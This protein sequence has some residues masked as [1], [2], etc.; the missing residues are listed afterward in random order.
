MSDHFSGP[1]AIAGPAG[2]ICDVYAFPS[3]E[4]PGRLVL[5]MTVVPQASLAARFSDA[6]VYRFRLR[7]LSVAG[8]GPA[9]ALRFG[10]P[11]QES[12][13]DVSF[14]PPAAVT[15]NR[16]SGRCVASDGRR[17]ELAVNDERGG[18]ADGLRV[19]AGLRSDPFFMDVPAWRESVISGRLAFK[20]PGANSVDRLNVLSVVVEVD[21]APLLQAAGGPLYAVVGETVVAG[22]LPIRI[23]RVGRPET[24]NV[25]LVW[26]EYD[27]VNRDM[28]LRDI[29]NLEDTFHTSKDYRGAYRARLNANLAV[30]DRLD[31]KTDWPLGADGTH[32]LT[33]LL[34]ADYLVVDLSKPYVDQSFLEI[35]QALLQGRAHATCGGRS[36]NEDTMGSLYTL[37]ISGGAQRIS[38][39][40]FQAT[41]PASGVFPYLVPPNASPNGTHAAPA[42][43]KA[44]VP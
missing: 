2:D 42:A 31:G 16:Q 19:Y 14:H 40:V 18:G 3:R 12:V 4:Q 11:E 38:D 6:I 39:G 44:A 13:F 20:T 7:P 32:P 30:F 41:T 17:V 37:L 5:V 33:E 36:L 28:E 26:K 25:M 24:K 35:E 21:C 34:L 15:G 22:K 10:P 9:A 23:E 27:T 1:R 8:S 43:E 29:Y